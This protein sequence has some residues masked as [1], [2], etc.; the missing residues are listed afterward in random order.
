MDQ[1]GID[2]VTQTS[3]ELMCCMENSKATEDF[4]ATSIT[5]AQRTNVVKDN[6]GSPLNNLIKQKWCK[7][8]GWS[9]H[10]TAECKPD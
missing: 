7:N 9:N 6:K 4:D 1:V 2:P 8:H 3:M 10:T 5:V